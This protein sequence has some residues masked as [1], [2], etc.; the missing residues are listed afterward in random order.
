MW[1]GSM[2]DVR[3]STFKILVAAIFCVLTSNLEPLTSNL[4]H[5]AQVID[6]RF[7]PSPITRDAEIVP[8]GEANAICLTDTGTPTFGIALCSTVDATG[9]LVKLGKLEIGNA[10]TPAPL[11]ADTN[12]YNPTGLDTAGILRI[13]AS[14]EVNLS[15]LAAQA[16]GRLIFIHNVGADQIHLLNQ[17]GLSTDVNR[18]ALPGGG[19]LTLEHSAIALVQYDGTA[20]RWRVVAASGTAN[21]DQVATEVPF[22]PSQGT[23]WDPAPDEVGAALDQ[24]GSRVKTIE[25]S[26]FKATVFTGGV[27][28]G[29]CDDPQHIFIKTDSTPNSAEIFI[30]S[31]NGATPQQASANDAALLQL[32]AESGGALVAQAGGTNGAIHGENG[33]VSRHA[34]GVIYVGQ[35]TA[36]RRRVCML[37]V[38]D[39]VNTIQDA[40]FSPFKQGRCY[41]PYAATVVEITL[42]GDAGT[43]SVTVQRRRDAST[44]AD[45]LSGALAGAGTTE[46]CA[47]AST[48]QTCINGTTSSGS[49]TLSN[50]AL[51][52]GDWIE[53]KSGTGSTA[54]SLNVAVVFTVN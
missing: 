21:D 13:S 28:A 43:P 46:T 35:T 49:I 9:K 25:L 34:S 37:T 19:A 27:P 48:S 38:G 52:A 3:C 20:A 26:G 24:L 47:M 31:A 50:T 23:D 8:T 40:D 18:F 32:A 33:N 44:L 16:A 1:V 10:I 4:S 12:N 42:Q 6:E 54:K 14:T 15:G 5:A 30:C 51:N 36:A 11:A 29:A 17:S 39:G 45:L 22:A 2:F 53:V 7:I 41:V